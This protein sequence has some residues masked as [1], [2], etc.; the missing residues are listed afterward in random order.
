LITAD[1]FFLTGKVALV[2]GSGRNIG[3]SIAESFAAFGA[4]VVINGRSDVEAIETVAAGIRERGGEALAIKADI[5]YE[6][7]IARLIDGTVEAFGGLDISAFNDDRINAAQ[8]QHTI[9]Q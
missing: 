9:K 3:R 2:T 1:S 7:D 6:Q 5:S 4:R 8:M